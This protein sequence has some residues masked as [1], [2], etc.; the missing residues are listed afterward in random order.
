MKTLGVCPQVIQSGREGAYKQTSTLL[1]DKG[2]NKHCKLMTAT[3]EEKYKVTK[4][5]IFSSGWKVR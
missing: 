3:R 1:R 2:I 5:M 4:C